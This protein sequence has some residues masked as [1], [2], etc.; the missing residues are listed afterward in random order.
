MLLLAITQ[1]VQSQRSP[2]AGSAN[3]FR[4]LPIA[5]A[6]EI[7]PS[8]ATPVR[9]GFDLSKTVT[10]TTLRPTETSTIISSKIP[11]SRGRINDFDLNRN[12]DPYHD[13]HRHQHHS[14][15]DDLYNDYN[16]NSGE[17]QYYDYG[18]F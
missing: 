11:I 4:G 12:S 5:L 1:R 14:H 3:R 2:Y 16:S 13:Y 15:G 8:I 9:N 18:Y 10:T 6:M 7:T 17:R